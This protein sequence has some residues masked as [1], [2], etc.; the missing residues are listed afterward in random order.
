MK[1]IVLILLVLLFSFAASANATLVQFS[2]SG[3]GNYN[4]QGV[5]IFDWVTGGTLV[6]EQQL[7]GSSIGATT[8][9]EFFASATN[10]DTLTFNIHAQ[11]SLIAYTE[12]DGTIIDGQGL[13]TDYELT[14]ILD[15]TE[16]ATYFDMGEH[17]VLMFGGITGSI[18]YYFDDFDGTV[19]SDVA[20]GAGF[21][22][23][24]KFMEGTLTSSG[25]TFDGTA[26]TGNSTLENTITWYDTKYINV[27]P[28]DDPSI[29][30]IGSSY[31]SEIKMA[32]E[33]PGVTFLGIPGLVGGTDYIGGTPYTTKYVD[34]F[35]TPGDPSDDI[36]DLIL[37]ADSNSVFSAIP[38]P[39]TMV[40]F[41][42]GLLGFAGVV[43][44]KNT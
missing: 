8:L 26:G 28:N 12:S 30:L 36:P 14:A 42:I 15:G 9:N 17:D 13:N 39:A 21:N 20:S 16:T 35:N 23:G 19:D 25:G 34:I 24:V 32:S 6:I 11:S 3:D 43:R 5:S 29:I 10:E 37:T 38:E 31:D 4:V 27:D 22:D 44:R 7:V 41:G 33:A 40:L 1:K 18:E 2:T